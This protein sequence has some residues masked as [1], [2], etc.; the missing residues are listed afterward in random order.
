MTRKKYSI[1]FKQQVIQEALETGNNSVVAKR[2]N[3]ST[4]MVSR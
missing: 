1:D 2:H 3:L 4:S